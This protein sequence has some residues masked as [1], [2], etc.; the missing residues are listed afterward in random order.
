MLHQQNDNWDR[1]SRNSLMPTASHSRF[2]LEPMFEHFPA[3]K[4]KLIRAGNDPM[5]GLA[6]LHK[7]SV[8]VTIAQTWDTGFLFSGTPLVDR[9]EPQ[10]AL[11]DILHAAAS[12]FSAKAVLLRKVERN[13]AFEQAIR[14]L[15]PELSAGCQ[16]FNVHERAALVCN[17][18]FD[19]WFNKNFSRKRRK[20]YRR[21]R[22][23][24]A[25]QGK[26]ESSAWRPGQPVGEWIDAFV[27]LE[28]AGWKG[29]NGTA[30]ACIQQQEAHLRH[31]LSDMAQNG[32]LLFWKITLDDKPIAVLFGFIEGD[33]AWLG[34]MAYDE[35]L[36]KFSPGVLV[37][38]DATQD[39]LNRKDITL[40]DSSA[41]PNH[42]MIDNIW[43][44]RLEVADYLIATPGTGK[45]MFS[46]IAASERARLAARK[47]AR[48]VYHKIR[49][50]LK[51]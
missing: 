18:D 5:R 4:A 2:W 31:A 6:A 33:Q 45:T 12:E 9:H 13:D 34:K 26:L 16:L 28:A 38:L 44:D 39:L 17:S 23:R 25:E 43:R 35:T 40:V 37:I 27:H 3:E 49:K 22:N 20:E 32:S 1:L 8:P 15:P 41:D 7:R 10:R 50:G 24:L 48:A 30:I 51:K 14:N 21:M 42:P 47:R 19:T 11:A 46:M 29:R 36:S